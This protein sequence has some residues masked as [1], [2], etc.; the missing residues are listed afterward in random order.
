[1]RVARAAGRRRMR[2]LIAALLVALVGASF[3]AV[4]HSSL[5][6]ARDV[7]VSGSAH[8]S[9]ESVVHAAG[10]EGAPP[11]VDLSARAIAARVERLPWVGKAVVTISWPSTVR[12]RLTD[13]VPVA[14]MRATR[15]TWAV[16]D[17]TGRVLE[18][19]TSPPEG[20]P[21]ITAG[22]AS[23]PPGG[24]LLSTGRALA[25][26]AA[27]M[28]ESMVPAVSEIEWRGDGVDVLLRAGIVAVLGST[29][30]LGDKFLALATVLAKGD[31]A[32]IGTVDLTVP[33]APV[34]I[35]KASSPIVARK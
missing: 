11:L 31:L 3:L 15:T 13:R 21:R 6:G 25:R 7:E 2:F 35:R 16:I 9:R 14:E 12:I 24:R 34:L 19:V 18:D 27:S 8:V 28:P 4:L 22:E 32:G 26:T 10:L 30:S 5:L 33:S 17:P 1:M 23:P 29:S 20:L